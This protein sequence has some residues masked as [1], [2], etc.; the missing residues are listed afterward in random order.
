[1]NP[2]ALTSY[3]DS[4]ESFPFPHLL[5][6]LDGIVGYFA[7][8][9]DE[10]DRSIRTEILSPIDPTTVV[11]KGE[12]HIGEGCEIDP[13]VLIEGPVWIGNRVTIRS[14]ALI[15]PGTIL[16]DDVVV[17]HGTEVKNVHAA[18][19]VKMASLT[20]VG[21]S[22]LGSAARIGSGTIVA[23]RR[24][25]QAAIV[26]DTGEQKIPTGKDKVG[27]IIG[28]R[29]R[30]GS[31][32]TLSPGTMIGQDA[33]IYSNASV[34]GLIPSRSIVKLR[35]QIEIAERRGDNFT[36]SYRDVNGNL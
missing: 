28:D 8:K 26:F 27:S 18:R 30:V 7:D 6:D 23:N 22:I 35:Q 10:L 9:K 14:G 32:V 12:V 4:V 34:A 17:G 24:F 13:F 11:I 21:D 25:D 20:F 2:L 16:G 19:E 31:N 1:M 29:T 36:L 15:R 5:R 33:L 3:F